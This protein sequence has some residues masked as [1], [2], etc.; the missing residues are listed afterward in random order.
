MKC[1]ILPQAP[2]SGGLV[3]L[4][5]KDY[6]YLVRVRRFVPGSVFNARLPGGEEVKVRV[7]SLDGVRLW[8]ECLTESAPPRDTLPPLVLFQALPKGTK[9]DLIVRQ[10]AEG[11][12]T[13]IFPFAAD[14]SVPK[15]RAGGEEE[16]TERWERIIKEARQQSGSGI[17]TVVRP[18]CKVD[19]LFEYWEILRNRYPGALGILMHQ[20]PLEEGTLHGYLSPVPEFVVLVIG[21]EGGFSPGELSRFLAADFKPLVLGNTVLRT[22]TAALYGMAAIRTIL[23]ESASWTPK[24]PPQGNGSTY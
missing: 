3:C 22:E 23:L 4:S 17:A 6:H 10:A 21:P 13:E 7:K 1:F 19:A 24:S 14:Y 11:G 18:P 8:G 12:L 5:G 2:D 16:K 9:M 15:I 20:S